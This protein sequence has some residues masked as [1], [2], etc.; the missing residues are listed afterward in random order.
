MPVAEGRAMQPLLLVH[1]EDPSGDVQLLKKLALWAERYSPMVG[2]EENPRPECLLIDITGCG[3]CFHGED[4][5]VE[6]AWAEFSKRGWRVQVAAGDTVGT[7]WGLAH[8]VDRFQLV[9]PGE[10]EQALLPLPVAALRLPKEVLR[11]LAELG[12][13]VI[14]Q[15][16][17]LPRAGLPGRFGPLVVERLDQALGRLPELIVPCRFR[18]EVQVGC[19]F[20]YPTAH[21][22]VLN[23]ALD[24]LLDRLVEMLRER[25]RGA[26]RLECWFYHEAAAP[27]C[28]EVHLFRP[29]RSVTHL[30]RLLHGRLEQIRLVEP[31]CGIRL[32]VA[33]AEVLPERQFELFDAEEPGAEEFSALID[34]LVGRLGREAVTF[35]SLVAD[36]QPE[37]ACR[38]EPA[39]AGNGARK[40]ERKRAGKTPSA[41]LAPVMAGVPGHRPVQVWPVPE[42]IEVLAV[43]PDRSAD[44][45]A[46]QTEM[47]PPMPARVRR[48]GREYS[49]QNAWGPERIETGWWR[50]QDVHRDYYMVETSAGQRW[51]IFRRHEDGRW[52]LHGCFD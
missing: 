42:P 14:G 22:K 16:A 5:L 36:P 44:A 30:G 45:K 24:R 23:L 52:F 10:S 43:T 27:V 11:N 18:P 8:Y 13:E 3:P 39:I 48:Q 17:N 38:F 1:E 50:G 26:R 51:W 47:S 46:G 25:N 37:F 41:L 15:L 35:A 29:S 12:I 7:A 33:V 20:E 9:P 28:L 21:R 2:L 40:A 34:R 6:R 49:V 31:V 19:T 32:R 4:R